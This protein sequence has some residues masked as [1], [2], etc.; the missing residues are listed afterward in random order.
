MMTLS[1][2]QPLTTRGLELARRRVW[3]KVA[4]QYFGGKEK[5]LCFMKE[6]CGL[7]IRLSDFMTFSM[8]FSM[9]VS[10]IFYGSATLEVLKQMSLGMEFG[11]HGD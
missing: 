6:I 10:V 4:P 5:H 1:R 2:P 9:T 11:G 3:T 8:T 7:T